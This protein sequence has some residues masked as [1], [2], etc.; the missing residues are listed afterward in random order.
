M[1]ECVAEDGSPVAHLFANGTHQCANSTSLFANS[2]ILCGNRRM[3]LLNC[4]MLFGNR[5][6][7][8]AER[9]VHFAM[10]GDRGQKS[11][12]AS[13]NEAEENRKLIL[14]AN[15]PTKKKI[16]TTNR[17][18]QSA[19]SKGGV[20]CCMGGKKTQTK[21]PSAKETYSL[22]TRVPVYKRYMLPPR[23]RNGHICSRTSFVCV[24]YATYTLYLEQISDI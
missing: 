16:R 21:T 2:I 9:G 14:F 18:V 10:G 1:V 13:F 3:Q 17:C 20:I 7:Q 23:L 6:P 12:D 8:S 19:N 24:W 22:R 4:I 11:S 15:G 5:P